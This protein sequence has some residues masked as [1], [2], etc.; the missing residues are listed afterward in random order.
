MRTTAFKRGAVAVVSA[1]AL[2]AGLVPATASVADSGETTAVAAA[3]GCN[4]RT[5]T[6]TVR[7]QKVYDGVVVT[8]AASVELAPGESVTDLPWEWAEEFTATAVIDGTSRPRVGDRLIAKASRQ[9][10]RRIKKVGSTTDR[11]T[12]P[13]TAEITNTTD[14]QDDFVAYRGS[15]TVKSYIVR[16]S[17]E[18]VAGRAPRVRW[19][20]VGAWASY[21]KVV[22]GV[23]SCNQTSDGKVERYAVTIFCR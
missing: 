20:R 13:P 7:S 23:G 3:S 21:L 10:G 6:P 2:G 4:P 8:H 15:V 16:S 5:F 9:T 12:V 22:Q 1:V 17:C 18:R 14:S 19:K 11:G